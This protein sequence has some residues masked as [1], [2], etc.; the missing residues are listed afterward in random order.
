MEMEDMDAL[1][2]ADFRPGKT[3]TL[4]EEHFKNKNEG[5]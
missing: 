3:M 2:S 4:P 5:S 1:T